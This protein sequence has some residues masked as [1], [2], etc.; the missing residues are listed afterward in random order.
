MPLIAT[1]RFSNSTWNE[2]V[3]FR[4]KYNY[5]GC[6]YGSPS[7]LSCKIDKDAVLFVIEMNNS[8]NKI[9]YREL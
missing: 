8:T 5:K 9:E 6:I 2:N 4:E 7:Q 3:S 1:T